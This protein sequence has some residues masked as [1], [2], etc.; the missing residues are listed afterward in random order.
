LEGREENKRRRKESRRRR[1]RGVEMEEG[2]KGRKRE[3]G[4][5]DMETEGGWRMKVAK[6]KKERKKGG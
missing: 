6:E 3:E 2:R 1:R 4:V 5:G